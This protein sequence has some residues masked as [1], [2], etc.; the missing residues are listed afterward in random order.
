MS[1]TEQCR[2]LREWHTVGKVSTN[3][4]MLT[5]VAPYYARTLGEWWDTRLKHLDAIRSGAAPRLQPEFEN[6]KLE[7]VTHS[8][9]N[10]DGYRD[11][12]TAFAFNTSNSVWDVEARFCDQYASGHMGLCEIRLRLHHYDYEDGE[13]RQL[14]PL[15]SK[16]GFLLKTALTEWCELG[17]F[18]GRRLDDLLFHEYNAVADGDFAGFLQRI[19]WADWQP[20][21]PLHGQPVPPH[22]NLVWPSLVIQT[23]IHTHDPELIAAI[24]EAEARYDVENYDDNPWVDEHGNELPR[25]PEEELA[26][27]AWP[28]EWRRVFGG[29]APAA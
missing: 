7:Q 10:P 11:S 25:D 5:I 16:F 4:G 13:L 12:E 28:G 18:K 27:L 21:G 6:I 17:R 3:N 23:A 8:V 22:R 29:G 24:L 14:T 9:T 19:V 2:D 20:G 15:A 26:A 1:E